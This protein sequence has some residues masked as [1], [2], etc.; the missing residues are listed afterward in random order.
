MTRRE[1]KSDGERT[2]ELL[3]NVKPAKPGKAPCWPGAGDVD[4][5][6]DEAE[7]VGLRG[8]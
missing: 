3:P 4:G 5:D 1:S 7:V 6:D 8:E 2:G